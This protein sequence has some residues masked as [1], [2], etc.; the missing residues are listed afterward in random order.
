[1][2]PPYRLEERYRS[3]TPTTNGGRDEQDS[4]AQHQQQPTQLTQQQQQQLQQ[5]QFASQFLQCS[6]CTEIMPTMA[7]PKHLREFHRV[8]Y[9]LNNA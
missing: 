2:L 8:T 3:G 6:L 1:M 5:A 9:Q 7:Y 4:S